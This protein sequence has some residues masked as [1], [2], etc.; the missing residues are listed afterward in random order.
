MS[1][2]IGEKTHL[3]VKFLIT[4]CVSLAF[5]QAGHQLYQIAGPMAGI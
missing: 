4:E 3:Q 1:K 5:Q 2:G